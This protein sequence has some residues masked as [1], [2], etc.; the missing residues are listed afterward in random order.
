MPT[1]APEEIE[2]A[3]HW[4]FN[5]QPKT[6]V[7][8]RLKRWGGVPLFVLQKTDL[9]DQA[10]LQDALNSCSLSN[11]V[12]CMAD[13]SHAS[14]FTHMLLHQ[15]VSAG[16][17][18]GPVEFALEWLKEEL[19]ARYMQF[20]Q[21]EV[22]RFLATSGGTPTIIAYRMAIADAMGI[23]PTISLTPALQ[24]RFSRGSAHLPSDSDDH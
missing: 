10:M 18:R 15:T 20:D 5:S 21:R 3:R 13:L 1:W 24:H 19:V 12:S 23:H 7:D 17:L 4:I 16:Y 14:G 9:A 11:F 22:Q 8:D 2:T 6:E